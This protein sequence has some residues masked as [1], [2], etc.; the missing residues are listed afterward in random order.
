MQYQDPEDMYMAPNSITTL[1][2]KTDLEIAL[3]RLGPS[4]S[5]TAAETAGAFIT[6]QAVPATDGSVIPGLPD[7]GVLHCSQKNIGEKLE[8]VC[9]LSV[10]KA[11]W[12]RLFGVGE[13]EEFCIDA[14]CEMANCICGSL[15]AD[16]AF[17]DEF[18]YLIPC[19]PCAGPGKP[20]PGTRGFGGAFRLGGAWVHFSLAMQQASGILARDAM[21]VA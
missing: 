21:M 18:G 6:A 1:K 14:F 4:L 7:L 17:T 11:E 13:S 16:P 3:L 8:L 15:I 2:A 12:E 5:R 10:E 9:N 19:V 20:H